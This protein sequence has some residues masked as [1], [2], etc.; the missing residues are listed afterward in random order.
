[1]IVVDPRDSDVVYVAA[2]GPLWSSG[3]DRGLY[4]SIDGGETWEAVLTIS[5]HTGVSEVHL[6]PRDPDVIYA[7]AHQRRRHVFTQIS[8]GPESGIYK[9]T[10]RRQK[11][12]KD[13]SG[14]A[15]G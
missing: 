1:M 4:K 9:S 8:G 13:Q 14:A 15:R 6:D 10:R 2:Y 7:T 11:L 3:G 12:E 5:E